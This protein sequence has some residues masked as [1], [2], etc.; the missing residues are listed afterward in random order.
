[1][2]PLHVYKFAV[3]MDGNNADFAPHIK[4]S[5]ADFAPHMEQTHSFRDKQIA[6]ISISANK[7]NV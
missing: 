4:G 7:K 3:Y 5:H 6:K 2:S 1:M